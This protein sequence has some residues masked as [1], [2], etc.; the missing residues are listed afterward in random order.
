MPSER[1]ELSHRLPLDAEH[2]FPGLRPY[3]E[4]DAAWF[5]GRGQETND[6]LKRLRRVRFLAVLGSSGLGKSSLVKAGLLP[7]VRDGYLDAS[8]SIAAFTPGNH[9]LDRLVTALGSALSCETREL[10]SQVDRGPLGLVEAIR[11]SKLPN[12]NLLVVVDQFEELFQLVQR[13][14]ESGE[15][16]VKAFLR[17]LLTAAASDAVPFFV[18]TTMRLEWLSECSAY[19]GLPEAINEGGYLVPQMT[20]RQF[21][22]AIL[23]P[24]EAAR[25]SITATLS[26]RLLNDLDART[27]QLPVL[28]HVLMRMWRNRKPGAPL[29]V[30]SYEAIGTLSESLSNHAR[31]VF[32][33]LNKDEQRA[34]E[35][36]FRSITEVSKN[37]RLRKPMPLG[38]I[39]EATGASVPQLKK[40]IE[41]FAAEGRSF[42]VVSAGPLGRDSIINISHE[43]LIRQWDRLSQWV[44]E[45][46]ELVSRTNRL[47]DIAG[48]WNRGRRKNR[49]LLYRGPVL[50]KAEE[51]KPRL[52]SDGVSMAF[53]KA[54]RKTQLWSFILWR[55]TIGI[56]LA[57]LGALAFFYWKNQRS[58]RLEQA[59]NNQLYEQQRSDLQRVAQAAQNWQQIVAASIQTTAIT[60]RP[61]ISLL[62]GGVRQLD[63]AR[64]LQGYLNG[65]G[66]LV[67]ELERVGSRSPHETQ[68]RYFYP[69]DQ[70][71]AE[72]LAN[73]LSSTV[74][75]V[76]AQLTS[77]DPKTPVLSGQ[78]EIW[79]SAA[80]EEAHRVGVKHLV[81]QIG[82]ASCRERV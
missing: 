27:D 5:F 22:Q 17:L 3:E 15:E 74:D 28:Q 63:L 45:E 42:L 23:K 24:V 79:L 21:Q 35:S 10:R 43:A 9:P 64:Q 57:S 48:E 11:S 8:W 25:G 60:T 47:Q 32:E 82:R 50:K 1:D 66:Y 36:L 19:A 68:V 31:E 54:S 40:I 44:D 29:D 13:K 33:T 39:A 46:A 2:P 37:R 76:K 14:G 77:F 58:L 49:A 4:I 70:L 69:Q 61:A 55:G 34:C 78:L 6:L 59:K 62:Y 53:L 26:D 71:D 38:E 81:V 67:T 80:A 12:T 7:A 16:E 65:Q 30:G 51:L 20:R 18:V 56:L 52:K 75:G 41:A 73:V 72:K